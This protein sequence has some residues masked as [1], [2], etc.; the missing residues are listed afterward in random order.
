MF[1]ACATLLT[2]H[3][4]RVVTETLASSV[5]DLIL[6][7]QRSVAYLLYLGLISIKNLLR[8]ALLQKSSRLPCGRTIHSSQS[9]LRSADTVRSYQVQDLTAAKTWR[10]GSAAAD[11][12][13]RNLD[14]S[15]YLSKSSLVAA[16]EQH[17]PVHDTYVSL[18][19]RQ[20][21]ALATE[22][23]ESTPTALG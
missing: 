22:Q 17:T 15:S 2:P 18:H 9:G 10:A 16:S 5:G 6:V 11:K 23:Y 14:F 19:S 4:T 8:S 1:S 3:F 20:M 7:S 21:S 13:R 12:L